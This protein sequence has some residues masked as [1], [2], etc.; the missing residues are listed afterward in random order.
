MSRFELFWCGLYFR[1]R[2]IFDDVLHMLGGD[3]VFMFFTFL[4]LFMFMFLF[5]IIIHW[6]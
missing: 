4:V 2:Y 3:I 6:L 5:H 1:W